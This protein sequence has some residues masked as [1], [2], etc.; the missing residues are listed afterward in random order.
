MTHNFEDPQLKGKVNALQLKDKGC[1]DPKTEWKHAHTHKPTFSSSADHSSNVCM[2]PVCILF[3]GRYVHILTH[4][5][6]LTQ[7]KPFY[8][9]YY[10]YQAHK[11]QNQRTQD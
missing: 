10:T 5:D 11:Q 8:F 3:S 4:T 2:V 9:L 7:L 1:Y 6:I